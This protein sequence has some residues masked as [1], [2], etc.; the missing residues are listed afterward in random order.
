MPDET[1]YLGRPEHTPMTD[2]DIDKLAD[3]MVAA[4]PDEAFADHEETPEV[5]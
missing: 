5:E 3:D 2:E 1:V 4:I